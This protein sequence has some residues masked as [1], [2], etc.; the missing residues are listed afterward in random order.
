MGDQLFHADR[1]AGRQAGRQTDRQT[2]RRTFRNFATAPAT[3]NKVPD[4]LF[5]NGMAYRY[6]R[7]FLRD[8]Q[9]FRRVCKLAKCD[10]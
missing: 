6:L 8:K 1:Q 10:Y 5:Q 3:V 9:V 2:D 4:T 7:V